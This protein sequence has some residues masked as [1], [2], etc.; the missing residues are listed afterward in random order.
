MIRKVIIAFAALTMVMSG[1]GLTGGMPLSSRDASGMAMSDCAS[2]M[3]MSGDKEALDCDAMGD[4]GDQKLPMTCSFDEC[5]LRGCS[6]SAFQ[7]SASLI[8]YSL[9]IGKPE[10]PPHLRGQPS[11]AG[12]PPLPPPR[13]SILT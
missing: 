8:T 13:S 3:A 2:M 10:L 1:F 4:M 9:P 11:L 6:A 7:I 12:R 5:S